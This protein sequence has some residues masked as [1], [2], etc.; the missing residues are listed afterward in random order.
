[1]VNYWIVL[2]LFSILGLIL[3]S[4]GSM[5]K[6]WIDFL[7]SIVL[8]H[9]YNGAW[10]YLKTYII[11]LLIPTALLLAPIKR[12]KP[13]ICLILC[14]FLQL[15]WYLSGK[16]GSI[17]VNNTIGT[18]LWT[19]FSNL[20]HVLPYFWCGALLCR[21]D[22]FEVSSVVLNKCKHP[23]IFM[24]IAFILLFIGSNAI[25]KAVLMPWAA[26]MVFILFNLWE[27]GE[28]FKD[29]FMFFGKHSTNIWLTHMF[30][31][32]CVFKDLVIIVKYPI[33]MLIFI[34]ILSI[35]SSYIILYI[36]CL[37]NR[38]QKSVV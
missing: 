23:K 9:S 24:N 28:V 36:R 17:T 14:V 21:I 12:L 35:I 7:E 26:V 29:F 30:F 4:D 11:L 15:G 32:A 16:Y 6:S 20:I 31:Y 2:C 37:L 8:L 5:P 1:M 19:E 22:V 13:W 38:L 3:P 18:C 27:K 33:L 25:H 10:W 34:F